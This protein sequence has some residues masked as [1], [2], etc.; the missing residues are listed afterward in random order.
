MSIGDL[1]MSDG[2]KKEKDGLIH[3]HILIGAELKDEL[4]ICAEK[5]GMKVS[6]LIRMWLVECVKKDK[7]A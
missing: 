2:S 1:K 5:K 3:L 4:Q 6:S 7:K